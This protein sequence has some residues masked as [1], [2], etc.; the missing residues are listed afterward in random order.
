MSFV[1]HSLGAMVVLAYL[2]RRASARPVD[3]DGLV[4]V[5][6]AAGRLGNAD[7][8]ACWQRRESTVCVDLLSTSPSRH[9]A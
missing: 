9:C 7:W 8:G 4:L 5:A 1:G 3:P 2:A 6:S